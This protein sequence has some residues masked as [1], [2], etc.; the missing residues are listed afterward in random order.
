MIIS[1]LALPDI[2]NF[3]SPMEVRNNDTITLSCFAD[4]S[5]IQ[6]VQWT[7]TDQVFGVPLY[8][9]QYIIDNPVNRTGRIVYVPL[10]NDIDE[11]FIREKFTIAPP[12]LSVTTR[13]YGQ[14]TIK[15]IT[16]FEAGEYNCTLNNKFGVES[17]TVT[18]EVQCKIILI[19]IMTVEPG[20]SDL[21]M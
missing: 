5:P 9:I 16:P 20:Y 6:S 13:L 11:N 15:G 21:I 19:I 12:D 8:K 4:G 7:V 1:S 18:V 14:L 3:S 10:V 17:R 2:V